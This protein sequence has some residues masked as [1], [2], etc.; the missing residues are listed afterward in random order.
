MLLIFFLLLCIS[1]C[2]I[3]SAWKKSYFILS[4]SSDFHMI[5]NLSIGVHV[6]ARRILISHS[7]DVTLLPPYVNLSSNFRGLQFRMNLTPS[8]LKPMYSILF[9]FTYPAACSRLCCSDS[10]WVGD[11][12]NHWLCQYYSMDAFHG[13]WQNS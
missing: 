2:C 5:D 1:L 10:A 11:F 7:V 12:S 8:Q 3:C 9:T 4:D 13:R 6:F